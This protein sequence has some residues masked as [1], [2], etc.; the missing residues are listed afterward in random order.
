[1]CEIKSLNDRKQKKS[2]KSVSIVVG[3]LLI[4]L[5]IYLK[6]IYGI[7][8]GVLLLATVGLSKK[9]IINQDGILVTYDVT[10]YKYRE[11]WRFIDIKELHRENIS[12]TNT[13]ALHFM[14][15]VMSK[16]ILLTSEDAEKVLEM[17]K[18]SN[19]QMHID[20]AFYSK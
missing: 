18:S 12:D 16:R 2:T 4:A 15:D 9:T 3:I 5:S 17:A 10:V 19:P 1:M 6:A 11:L 20:Y 7:I 14:K 13:T 8:C